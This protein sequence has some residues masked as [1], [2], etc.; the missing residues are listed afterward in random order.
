MLPARQCLD[1]LQ[2]GR[3]VAVFGRDVEPKFLWRII[4]VSN[5]R[6][7]GDRHPVTQNVGPRC[8]PLVDNAEVVVDAALQKSQNGR[9]TRRPR[10][11]AQEAVGA[12]IAV[13]LL[14][15]EDDPA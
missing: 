14:V 2:P 6:K 5:Q 9:I 7:V 13:D 10:Q 1:A 3:N 8:E 12:E 4:K 11:C 15:V